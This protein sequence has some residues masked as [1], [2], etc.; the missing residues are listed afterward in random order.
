MSRRISKQRGGVSRISGMP[1][2]IYGVEEALPHTCV[3]ENWLRSNFRGMGFFSM[4]I[5][6]EEYEPMMYGYRVQ[7][8]KETGQLASI[9]DEMKSKVKKLYDILLYH[10]TVK[11]SEF[12]PTMGYFNA[13][14]VG[15]APYEF[16]SYEPITLPVVVE[17]T[18][19]VPRNATNA[20]TMDPITDGAIMANFH[21]ES[22]LGRFYKKDT[23]NSMNPKRNPFTRAPIQPSNVSYYRARVPAAGGKRKTRRM[24]RH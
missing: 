12:M 14:N 2:V 11:R 1:Y 9:S 23:Y 8:N 19:N 22:A 24:R 7:L 15:F 18:R 20:I 17:N 10:H 5:T 4:G 21:G 16:D 6:E 3:V 13:V